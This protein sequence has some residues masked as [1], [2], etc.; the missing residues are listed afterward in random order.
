MSILRD[1]RFRSYAIQ[2]VFLF[3][4]VGGFSVLAM[5]TAANL[6]ARGIPLGIGFLWKPAGF[7]IAETI[8]PYAPTD[9]NWWAAAVGVANSLFVSLFVIVL[10]SILGLAIGVGRLSTNPLVSGVCR[11]WVEIARNTPLV[12]LLIFVYALWWQ[13]LPQVREAWTLLPGVHV[14]LRGLS[15]PAIRW[16]GAYAELLW[17]VLMS[18]AAIAA[19]AFLARRRRAASGQRTPVASIGFAILATSLALFALLDQNR[20]SL[21]VPEFGR[22]NFVGGWQLTPEMTTIL[23]GLTFYTA[24]FIGEIVRGGINAVKKGQWEAAAALGLSR[25]QTYRLVVIPLALRTIVPPMNSQYIN[26]V[27]NSTLA[28]V[29]GYQ[30]FM[31]IMTTMINKTSHA[32]EGIVMILGVFLVINL[33]MSLVLNSYNRRIAIVER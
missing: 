2:A 17:P 14:S 9:P 23:V 15:L 26:V 22:A 3:V 8:L 31:T 21:E 27:K 18:V 1:A 30:D 25:G 13:V 32:I 10:A 4:I 16:S 12:V 6:K 20:L 11:I 29:V 24:G 5:A 28:I 33:G 7:Q 19:L